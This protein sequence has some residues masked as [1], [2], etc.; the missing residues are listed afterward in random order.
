[1]VAD[2]SPERQRD[3]GCMV[4]K[5]GVPMCC[6]NSQPGKQSFHEDE[7]QLVC[8]EH[9]VVEF[10]IFSCDLCQSRLEV[11]HEDIAP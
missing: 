2:N 1:M 4:V 8:L 7:D 10:Q 5:L 6:G 9:L 3:K 11:H